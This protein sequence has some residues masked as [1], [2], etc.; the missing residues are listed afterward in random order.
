[1]SSQTWWVEIKGRNYWLQEGRSCSTGEKKGHFTDLGSGGSGLQFLL[2]HWLAGWQEPVAFLF[3][4]PVSLAG[5][6]FPAANLRRQSWWM[7]RIFAVLIFQNSV[8]TGRKRKSWGGLDVDSWHSALWL[9]QQSL[10]NLFSAS[11]I[12]S[13]PH[14]HLTLRAA[15][16]FFFSH[17]DHFK[18]LY[19]ICYNIASVC[20]GVFFFFFFLRGMWDLSSPTR[21]WTHTPCIRPRGKSS[22]WPLVMRSRSWLVYV[23][24]IP[25]FSP[26]GT[27][28]GAQNKRERTDLLGGPVVNTPHSQC[29]ALHSIPC[30]GT[31]SHMLQL[32]VHMPLQRLKVPS[33]AAKT[34]H[35]QINK[36]KLN[37]K[38]EREKEKEVSVG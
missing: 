14:F 31:R 13:P 9:H 35:T 4:A 6:T 27:G 37:L 17:M 24:F 29:K 38:K 28:R 22:W 12:P 18:R 19:W 25:C 1:M 7:S 23:C 15:A 21:D 32:R 10:S 26:R 11:M 5:L 20:F 30:Q 33:A 16:S 3:Y 8:I 2:S 36:H 34:W